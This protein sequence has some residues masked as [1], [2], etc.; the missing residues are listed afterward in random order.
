MNKLLVFPL[1]ALGM[2]SCNKENL[3]VE[4]EHTFRELSE[5]Q[6]WELIKMSGQMRNSETTGG[7]MLWQEYYIFNPDRSFLKVR[8]TKSG[9]V[10]AAGTYTYHATLEE[11]YIELIYPT[12]SDI[13]GSCNTAALKETLM[14]KESGLQGTW[15]ACDGPGLWYKLAD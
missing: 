9:S 3:V 6:K 2:I 11:K 12:D 10:S 13:I 4:A 8:V 5:T 14:V 7:D 1:L 15:W